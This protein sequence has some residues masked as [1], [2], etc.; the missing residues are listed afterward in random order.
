MIQSSVKVYL[1]A[2]STLIPTA[3]PLTVLLLISPPITAGPTPNGL[4]PT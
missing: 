1:L 2:A 4:G 3:A